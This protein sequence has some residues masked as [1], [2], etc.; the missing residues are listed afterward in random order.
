MALK[1]LVCEHT[2]VFDDD[3]ELVDVYVCGECSTVYEENDD[4]ITNQMDYIEEGNK[5]ICGE[6]DCGTEL[7]KK[8]AVKCED[9]GQL[10][11][12]D[13]LT[14]APSEDNDE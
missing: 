9:C 2:L 3:T 1:Q 5:P 4:V 13:D 10:T 6:E 11:V 14:D 7:E 12:V 8:Q